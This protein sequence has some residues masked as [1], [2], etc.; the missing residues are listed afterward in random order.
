MTQSL[1]LVHAAKYMGAGRVYTDVQLCMAKWQ[2]VADAT[3]WHTIQVPNSPCVPLSPPLPHPHPKL[4]NP[5]VTIPLHS[6]EHFYI[7]TQP[8]EGLLQSVLLYTLALSAC[9]SAICCPMASNGIVPYVAKCSRSIIFAN[10]ANGAHS[11][12]LLFAN[13]Y[14]RRYTVY[15]YLCTHYYNYGGVTLRWRTSM[16]ALCLVKPSSGRSSVGS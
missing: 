4:T 7:V 2:S 8:I 15:I 1:P 3:K 5:P 14:V 11:R 9:A 10:F 16:E 12:I 6:V 13:F